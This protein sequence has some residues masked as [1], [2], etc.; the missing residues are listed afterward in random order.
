MRIRFLSGNRFK[1][2][3]ATAIL[4]DVNVEVVPVQFAVTELQTDNTVALVRDKT[5]KAF[6]RLGHK[7]F[8]EQTGLFID[9]MCGLPGGLTQ[10]FWDTLE[11]DRVC[12]LFGRGT[13]VGVTAKTRIGYCDGRTIHQFEGEIRGRFAAEPRGDRS[14][15]WDCVFIPEGHD[16]TFAEMGERKNEISMRRRALDAF[17]IHLKEAAVA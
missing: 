15:Q 10:V 17:A 1:I 13:E 4:A 6:H 9:R 5:L 8:V 11:A 7:V 12:E 3:E 14:F 2:D 16:E